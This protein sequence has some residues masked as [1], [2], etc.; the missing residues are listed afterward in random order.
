MKKKNFNNVR[1]RPAM[2]LQVPPLG[3]RS[4]LLWDS[5]KMERPQ[6]SLASHRRLSKPEVSHLSIA[7]I[8]TWLNSGPKILMG[9]EVQSHSRGRMPKWLPSLKIKGW[10]AI[11]ETIVGFLFSMLEAKF[12]PPSSTPEST[13]WLRI[14]LVITNV[15]SVNAGEL[16]IKFFL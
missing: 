12:V 2:I 14:G 5:C 4:G 9:P 6:G 11:L 13:S 1:Q 3:M 7:F 8:K 15:A 16:L 10:R